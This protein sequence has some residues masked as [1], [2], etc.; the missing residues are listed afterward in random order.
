MSERLDYYDDFEVRENFQ[1]EQKRRLCDYTVKRLM[2]DQDAKFAEKK[3]SLFIGPGTTAHMFFE[4]LVSRLG[5]TGD[6][7]VVSNNLGILDAVEKGRQKGQHWF[8]R[9]YGE[10]VDLKNRSLKPQPG[11]RLLGCFKRAKTSLAVISCA[12]IW[13]DTNSYCI[14]AFNSNHAA[15][16]KQVVDCSLV[17]TY[18]IADDWKRYFDTEEPTPEQL[19]RREKDFC[20]FATIPDD[21][22]RLTLVIEKQRHKQPKATSGSSVMDAVEEW[23]RKPPLPTCFL[24]YSI[25]DEHLVERLYTDLRKK[26]IKS[27][28]W[29]HGIRPGE[30]L[31]DSIAEAI[32]AHPPLILICNKNS[33]DSKEVNDELSFA[34]EHAINV[35]S[36]MTDDY[37]PQWSPPARFYELKA[38]IQ[39]CRFINAKGWDNDNRIYERVLADL[40]GCLQ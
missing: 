23:W 9:L 40:L 13:K 5:Q 21:S 32:S 37:F 36:V 14:G 19:A 3:L 6:F 31:W 25:Y 35:I 4:A 27:W 38:K 7:A 34:F 8:L 26:G 22:D 12:S 15:I 28:K 1:R 2:E 10:E 20:R 16:L 39:R 30:E 33:L 17:R 11:Q 18:L 29:D 24:S